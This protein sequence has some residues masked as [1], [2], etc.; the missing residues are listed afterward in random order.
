MDYRIIEG[1]CIEGMRRLEGQSV[2]CVVT[3]PPYFGLRQYLF[4]QAVVVDVSLPHEQR[5]AIESEMQRRGILPRSADGKIQE[6][7]PLEGTQ[8]VP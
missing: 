6:G 8:G 5:Q 2:N 4:D 1:D 3:S 7:S